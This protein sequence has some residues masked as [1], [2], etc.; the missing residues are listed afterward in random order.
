MISKFSVRRPVTILMIILIVILIGVVS[1]T[2]L[3]IDLLPNIEFPIA[4]V[5]TS[6]PGVSPEE[7]ENLV[8]KPLENSLTTVGNIDTLTSIS[9]E[10]SSLI[11][12]QLE[13]GTDMDFAALEMREKIDMVKGFLP[14]G[15]SDP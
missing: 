9:S 4:V 3:P 14:E 6:Y 15:A 11:I 1:L 12:L 8:T 7:I 10:G 13:F 5:S 2:E